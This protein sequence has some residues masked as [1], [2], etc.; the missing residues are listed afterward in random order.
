MLNCFFLK[1]NTSLFLAIITVCLFGF[2][3]MKAQ[4]GLF[5]WLG[6]ASEID[7][8][9]RDAEC[10]F[11]AALRIDLKAFKERE[12]K[13]NYSPYAKRAAQMALVSPKMSEDE[14]HARWRESGADEKFFTEFNRQKRR[15]EEAKTVPLEDLEIIIQNKT[16]PD[17]EKLSRY[18][19]RQMP[20]AFVQQGKPARDF[21]LKNLRS[22]WKN[23]WSSVLPALSWM[24]V[25]DIDSLEA[26]AAK[27]RLPEGGADN[28]YEWLSL[29]AAGLC[30][31]GNKIQGLRVLD[32][33]EEKSSYWKP[34]RD[35][36]AMD[37]SA[38]APALLYCRGEE[39][40]MQHIDAV[41]EEMNRDIATAEKKF[42]TEK[43]QKFVLDIIRSE[44]AERMIQPVVIWLHQQGRYEEARALYT[45]LP[46]REFS[47]TIGEV[48]SGDI[49]AAEFPEQDYERLIEFASELDLYSNNPEVA[50]TYF[51]DKWDTDFK[52]CCANRQQ[53]GYATDNIKKIWSSE[54]AKK[55]ALKNVAL[56][57]KLIA[58]K[59]DEINKMHQF[60]L[61]LA[62]IEKQ[63][64]CK[65]EDAMLSKL[66][67]AIPSYK[68]TDQM[69]GVLT[70]YIGYLETDGS[71]VTKS[72]CIV[73]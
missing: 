58:K 35:K 11:E 8:P 73:K 14:L 17:G 22:I 26:Y 16:T 55:A 20:I 24:A 47:M 37:R 43:E 66:L 59:P 72:D 18:L 21:W 6:G 56:Y 15:F 9:V 28:P 36:K 71:D 42:K 46:P 38:L 5:D 23:G 34:E 60:Q 29:D 49:T 33:L 1:K 27:F 12:V 13:Q 68:Y 52:I 48:A 32:V 61:E 64:G 67:K 51:V 25:Y 62:T 65:L 19:K 63:D 50:L 40:V 39:K 69:V 44:V 7:C 53:L 4:A 30:K 54:L 45:K 3:Q 31:S 41:L 57:N 70:T 10:L 2:S